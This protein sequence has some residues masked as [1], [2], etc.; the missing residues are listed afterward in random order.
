MSGEVGILAIGI[1]S[2]CM[3]AIGLLDHVSRSI[4]GTER[5]LKSE[6]PSIDD[7]VGSSNQESPNQEGIKNNDA[8]APQ[9]GRRSVVVFRSNVGPAKRKRPQ[10]RMGVRI[11]G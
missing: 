3:L 6:G 10:S 11:K 8:T 4:R 1:L 2:T 9:A 7:S 5:A